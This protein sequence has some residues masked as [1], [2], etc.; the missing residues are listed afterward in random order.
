MPEVKPGYQL[1]WY[2]ATVLYLDALCLCPLADLSGVQPAARLP[3]SSAARPLGSCGDPPGDPYVAGQRIA[4]FPGVLGVQVDL[5][6]RAVQAEADGSL[7]GAAVKVVDEQ[8][9]Y[10][11]SHGRSIPLTA[12]LWRTSV[13]IQARQAYS[14]TGG[15]SCHGHAPA[16]AVPR[17]TGVLLRRLAACR[18]ARVGGLVS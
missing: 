11:L 8:G 3:A 10:L 4:Q 9:L 2:P 12:D 13:D 14:R 16:D 7:G 6:L 18:P 5:V 1:I 15:I 17:E